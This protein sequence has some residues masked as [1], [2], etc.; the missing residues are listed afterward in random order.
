MIFNVTVVYSLKRSKLSYIK[1]IYR[2]MILIITAVY[3]F[4]IIK[5]LYLEKSYW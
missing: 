2:K 3:Y 1:K 5:L 4:G